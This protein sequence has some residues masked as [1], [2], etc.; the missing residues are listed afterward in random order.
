MKILIVGLGVIGGSLAKALKREKKARVYAIDQNEDSLLDALS[1]GA[2]DGKA[3]TADIPQMDVIFLC[4]YP[5]DCLSFVSRHK[6][7]IAKGTIVTD[8]CGVKAELCRALPKIA[9][10]NG[11]SYVA[12]HPMAGKEKSG[13][14][15]SDPSMFAGASYILVDS[16][17]PNEAVE[18]VVDLVNAMGFGRIVRT[19]AETHDKMI[20]FTSQLPHLLACAYVM[21]PQCA[22]HQGFSAG[23]YRD[24]SRVADI[25]GSLWTR[26]FLENREA[27]L[28]ELD[29]FL[30]RL[31]EMKQC[32][33]EADAHRLEEMLHQAAEMK[34]RDR[35]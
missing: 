8:V 33:K 16:G 30:Q 28:E 34:R 22:A 17:A 15:S 35:G 1:M 13:F 21:S 27:V 26:L 3:T 4:L 20:A 31:E 5:G 32:M 11:F 23:S 25:N 19:D 24:V 2:I 9:A 29:G 18:I 14:G 6:E 10:E 12:G 7:Q